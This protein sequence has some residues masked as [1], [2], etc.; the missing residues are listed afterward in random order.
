[1]LTEVYLEL[2]QTSIK[3]ILINSQMFYKSF[4]LFDAVFDNLYLFFIS[5]LFFLIVTIIECQH[6][7]AMF[8]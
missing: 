3:E 1:M 5:V 7:Q 2:S 8:F 6:S 4:M